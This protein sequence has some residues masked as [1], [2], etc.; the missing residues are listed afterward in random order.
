M[1]EAQKKTARYN[2]QNEEKFSNQ[3]ILTRIE[4]M[5]PKMD[6]KTKENLAK[7]IYKNTHEIEGK[8]HFNLDISKLQ[9]KEVNKSQLEN[10]VEIAWWHTYLQANKTY[11]QHLQKILDG[12]PV[13]LEMNNYKQKDTTD[14]IVVNSPTLKNFQKQFLVRKAKQTI[15]VTTLEYAEEK[16]KWQEEEAHIRTSY[17]LTNIWEYFREELSPEEISLLIEELTFYAAQH[18][19]GVYGYWLISNLQAL[20]NEE[21]TQ[22]TP[23]TFEHTTSSLVI[24]QKYRVDEKLIQA[25]QQSTTITFKHLS[26]KH[27]KI[28]TIEQFIPVTIINNWRTDQMHLVGISMKDSENQKIS[29]ENPEMR[30]I[31]LEGLDL[32]SITEEKCQI[33]NPQELYHMKNKIMMMAEM[34]FALPAYDLNLKPETVVLH[35]TCPSEYTPD[36][37][38]SKI[39]YVFDTAKVE[40]LNDDVIHCQFETVNYAELIPWIRK[41]GRSCQ[42]VEPAKLKQRFI[43]SVTE[44]ISNGK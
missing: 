33:A 38:S 21:Q 29:A 1:A 11:L 31:P 3:H 42:I 20:I 13:R 36:Q 43:K 19:F 24:G 12:L 4:K 37:F 2:R 8:V 35:F 23:I 30:I 7:E 5:Y 39:K 6:K 9:Y 34:T 14:E 27:K 22:R 15:E 28:V 10:Y 18:P 25:M 40:Q 16:S 17:L 41:F 32:S 26:L 44:A